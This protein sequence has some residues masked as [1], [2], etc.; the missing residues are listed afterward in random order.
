MIATF[1]ARIDCPWCGQGI[2]LADAASAVQARCDE[3][4]TVVELADP[5]PAHHAAG[6]QS[7]AAAAA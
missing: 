5:A 1:G 7:P 2:E 4:S 6:H 3:C